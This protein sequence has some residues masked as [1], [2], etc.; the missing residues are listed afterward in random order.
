M[1]KLNITLFILGLVAAI[2]LVVVLPSDPH[3]SSF[4]NRSLEPR[5]TFSPYQAIHHNFFGRLESYLLD[6]TAFRTT[7]LAF[8][9]TLENAYGLTQAGIATMVDF[10][11]EDLGFGLTPLPLVQATPGQLIGQVVDPSEPFGQ[12]LHFHENAIFYLRYRENQ[13]TAARYAQVL[14]AYAQALPEGVRMFSMLAPVKVEFMAER[15]QAANS[16]QR[17][18][19]DFVNS[20][21]SPDIIPVDVHGFLAAHADQYLFFRLDHHWTA[22]GAYYA[23]LAFAQAADFHPIT[24]ENYTQY[25][26]PGFVGSLALGTRNQ[27]ILD[28][29]DTI[30]FYRIHDGTTFSMDLFHIPEDLSLACYRIFLG[31]DRDFIHFTSSNTNGRTLAV[32]KDSFANALV[33]WLAP[34]YQDIV[35]FD[36]RQFTGSIIEALAGFE[37]IDLLFV[38]YMPATTMADLIEQIYHAK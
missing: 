35:M 24:I 4:E 5:P 25:T 28:H 21:L 17:G 18:T 10:A 7:W 15:Y 22:L 14:N 34:H 26:I 16:S 30:H 36:P 23:Y 8:G 2:T 33:P 29:P 13:E 37:N 9:S 32:V 11:G 19:V 6:N 31:G 20:L 12:D 27:T 1:P 3:A 38:N